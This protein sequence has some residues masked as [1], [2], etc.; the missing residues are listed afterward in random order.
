[1]WPAC[2]TAIWQT[3]NDG[4][5]ESWPPARRAYA[6]ERI[7]GMKQEKINFSCQECILTHYSKIPSG[8]ERT[9]LF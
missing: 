8:A 5:L 6:S 4:I 3:G 9:K 2:L 7:L 1:M